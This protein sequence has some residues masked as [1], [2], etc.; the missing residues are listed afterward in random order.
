[1]RK[2]SR[3]GLVI[4]FATIMLF[5]SGLHAIAQ[6]GNDEGGDG[7]EPNEEQAKLEI[8]E[9]GFEFD[10]TIVIPG[11]GND[12]W[13][14]E[15]LRIVPHETKTYEKIIPLNNPGGVD[16]VINDN[17]P[18][19]RVKGETTK[20][21][22]EAR[23]FRF[24]DFKVQIEAN[25]QADYKIQV[26]MDEFTKDVLPP[27]TYKGYIKFDIE[28]ST[29]ELRVPVNVTVKSP[30]GVALF[31]IFLGWIARPIVKGLQWLWNLATIRGKYDN[32]HKKIEDELTG[33]IALDW[34]LAKLNSTWQDF[35]SSN[36]STKAETSIKNLNEWI[37]AG[38]KE[39]ELNIKQLVENGQIAREDVTKIYD[40]MATLKDN[41][42]KT[43]ISGE[44]A[45]QAINSLEKLIPATKGKAQPRG[46]GKVIDGV[47]KG[48]L[49]FLGSSRWGTP[50]QKTVQFLVWVVLF[51]GLAY[52]GMHTQYA[53]AATWG[54]DPWKDYSALI[55]WTFASDYASMSVSEFIK[56]VIG[57]N[58]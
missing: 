24:D 49:N 18:L 14:F 29:E 40:Q 27:D 43:I 19:V 48:I 1:M 25:E 3:I 35:V 12:L 46:L 47:Y 44:A 31:M 6:G 57:G 4:A 10:P 9:D 36:D 56:K 50:L 28:N 20:R 42:G 51:V 54:A 32:L 37:Q 39:A 38:L 34:F 21:S 58:Q 53:S 16:A 23:H 11:F 26:N 41:S 15:L 22:L 13:G 33:T 45:N 7:D 52:W 17:N 30:A 55:T 5:F 8:D 2:F